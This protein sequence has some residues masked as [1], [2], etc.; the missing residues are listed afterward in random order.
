MRGTGDG[1]GGS[2][3]GAVSVGV[4]WW[5]DAGGRGECRAAVA[6]SGLCGGGDEV[7]TGVHV[8]W[9]KRKREG[10]GCCRGRWWSGNKSLDMR[11]TYAWEGSHRSEGPSAQPPS[12]PCVSWPSEG[13]QP[14]P[15]PWAQPL[16]RAPWEARGAA[17]CG[18]LVGAWVRQAAEG[19]NPPSCIR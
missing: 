14:P 16:P 4:W 7:A 2:V 13:F 15:W 12:S 11:G 10:G 5:V 1:S 3:H 18:L 9:G 6:S 8:V 17:R 19:A